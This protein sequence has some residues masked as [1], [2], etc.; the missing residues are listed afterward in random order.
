MFKFLYWTH[1]PEWRFPV[2]HRA[3]F[4]SLGCPRPL[5]W[6]FPATKRGFTASQST[7]PP[8]PLETKTSSSTSP[9]AT[10][11]WDFEF[12]FLVLQK[13][14]VY[15]DFQQKTDS[16]TNIFFI[17]SRVFS[18]WPARWTLWI[19]PCWMKLPWEA[20]D[21]CR[22]VRVSFW[23]LFAT[24]PSNSMCFKVMYIFHSPSW[25]TRLTTL[26]GTSEWPGNLMLTCTLLLRNVIF[27]WTL[28]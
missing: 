23:H 21:C 4:I 26:C 24:C 13:L 8:S 2:T 10:E 25:Q 12:W 16:Q 28:F 9:S 6:E 20:F 15:Q 18:S 19:C 17:F 27:I 7:A 3:C 22:Y 14:F 1:H 5:L 11:R